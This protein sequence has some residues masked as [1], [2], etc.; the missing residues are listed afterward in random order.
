MS[1]SSVECAAT[2]SARDLIAG[3]NTTGR[4]EQELPSSQ[5]RTIRI[6]IPDTIRIRIRRRCVCDAVCEHFQC[7]LRRGLRGVCDVAPRCC[8]RCDLRCCLRGVCDCL[9]LYAAAPADLVP[10]LPGGRPFV[11]LLDRAPVHVLAGAIDPSAVPIRLRSDCDRI[12]IAIASHEIE[13]GENLSAHTWPGLDIAAG[14]RQDA[15]VVRDR[16]AAQRLLVE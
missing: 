8:L 5:E 6:R 13:P 7:G 12:A 14:P 3:S 1:V 10:P 15:L 9:A 16:A 2:S 11:R 4:I